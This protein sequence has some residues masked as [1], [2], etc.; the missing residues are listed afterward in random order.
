MSNGIATM[1]LTGSARLFIR[2]PT[3]EMDMLD[4]WADAVIAAKHRAEKTGVA[5]AVRWPLGHYTVEDRKPSLRTREFRVLECF[6]DG[7]EQH[8]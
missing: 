6:E 3:M 2:V 5:Y 7:T 8:A 1:L 4:T